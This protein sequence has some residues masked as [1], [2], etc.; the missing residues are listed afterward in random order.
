MPRRTRID[1][2]GGFQHVICRGIERKRISQNEFDR[3]DFL[4]RL[5][6]FTMET[7]TRCLAWALTTNHFHLLIKA[8]PCACVSLSASRNLSFMPRPKS[9]AE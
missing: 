7:E 4:N 6:G 8:G 3:I 5:L 1:A 2:P 9:D